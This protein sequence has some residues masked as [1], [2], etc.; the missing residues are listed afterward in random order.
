MDAPSPPEP[1][2]APPEPTRRDG[3]RLI[4][5]VVVLVILVGL[6]ALAAHGLSLWWHDRLCL[7]DVCLTKDDLRAFLESRA[8]SST[9]PGQGSPATS[10][11]SSTPTDTEPPTL[12]IQGDN[13]ATITV[14]DTYADLGAI[15]HDNSGIA[16][17]RTYQGGSEVTT[18]RINTRA[19]GSYLIE[20]RATDPSG[21][22]ATSSRSVIVQAGNDNPVSA[23]ST[24]T[25][26]AQ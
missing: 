4:G 15:A 18:P 1:P 17:V 19:P 11:A 5:L 25:S 6:I 2:P 16:V 13:P 12:T 10:T 7:D 24:A 3:R 21:N 23:S 20:Y 8:A 22:L 26:S 14:G 9:T